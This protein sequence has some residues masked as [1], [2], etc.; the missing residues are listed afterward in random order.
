AFESSTPKAL[1]NLVVATV[2]A[3]A[4]A[5]NEQVRTSLSELN[6]RNDALLATA[7]R[8]PSELSAL[9]TAVPDVPRTATDPLDDE[10]V[11]ETPANP[12]SQADL[13]R[14]FEVEPDT[15]AESPW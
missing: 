1:A 3:A 15:E 11:D 5:A 12:P 2:Q 10:V 14:Y 4:R 9:R 6:Q 8:K 13:D 7:R